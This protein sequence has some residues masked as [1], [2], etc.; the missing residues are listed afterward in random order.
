MQWKSESTRYYYMQ[1]F[2][3]S[4][5]GSDVEHAEKTLEPAKS[6]MESKLR[7]RQAIRAIGIP[8][9]IICSNWACCCP[10]LVAMA[11]R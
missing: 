10:G 11:L 9:T 2:V 6:M 3:P 1:R 5:F 8:H 4:E 7:V